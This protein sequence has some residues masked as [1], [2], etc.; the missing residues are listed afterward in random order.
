[1][2]ASRERLG[3]MGVMC[4]ADYILFGV[5]VQFFCLFP[6]PQRLAILLINEPAMRNE[7]EIRGSNAKIEK[8][9]RGHGQESK[10]EKSW[11]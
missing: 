1:M 2:A 6:V 10:N 11:V 9:R 4:F 3:F 8:A 5:R 7:L